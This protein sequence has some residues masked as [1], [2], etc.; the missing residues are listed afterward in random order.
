MEALEKVV[1]EKRQH[2]RQRI[3]ELDAQF[4]SVRAD[5]MAAMPTAIQES[6]FMEAWEALRLAQR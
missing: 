2:A 4:K 3:A 6:K 5:V 1:N